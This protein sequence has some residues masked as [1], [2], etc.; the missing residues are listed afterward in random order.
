MPSVAAAPNERWSTDLA[1]I[2][3][4][5]DDWASLALIIDCHTRELLGWHLSKS[6]KATTASAALKHALMPRFGILGRDEE[7]FPLRSDNG[8]VFTRTKRHC[9]Q[10]RL[11]CLPHLQ[12]PQVS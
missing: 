5:K 7:E 4:G 2:W 8:L 6:G 11:R 10:C 1:P 3:T 12:A 9:K